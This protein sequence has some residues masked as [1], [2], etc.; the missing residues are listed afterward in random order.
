MTAPTSSASFAVIGSSSSATTN[1]LI[2]GFKWGSS[3]V[4]S[5]V[6]LSYSFPWASGGSATFAG[7]NGQSYSDLSE[8]NTGAA[9]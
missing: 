1:A 8:Q 4:G 5:S 2:S 9:V 7:L 6:S 3:T